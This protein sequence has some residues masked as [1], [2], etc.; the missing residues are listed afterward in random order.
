MLI[1]GGIFYI[2]REMKPVQLRVKQQQ[3]GRG[4]LITN[5]GLLGFLVALIG[6]GVTMMLGRINRDAFA[7]TTQTNA[8]WYIAFAI[9]GVVLLSG[10]GMLCISAMRLL[11][12]K[13]RIIEP[14]GR[15]AQSIG[16]ITAMP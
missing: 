11:L 5:L 7:A 6:S 8:V 9:F 13:K 12:L 15:S 4:I 14:S 3:V 1:L 10:I 2:L 16:Q